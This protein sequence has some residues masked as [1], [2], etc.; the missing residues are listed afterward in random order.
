MTQIIHLNKIVEKWGSLWLHVFI[1]IFCCQEFEVLWIN[2]SNM[3]L[4]FAFELQYE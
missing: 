3:W 2:M 4:A 1:D